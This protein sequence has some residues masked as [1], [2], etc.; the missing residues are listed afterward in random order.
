MLHFY[1][2]IICLLLFIKS[3]WLYKKTPYFKSL[4][5]SWNQIGNIANTNRK[6]YSAKI[7]PIKYNFR[8]KVKSLVKTLLTKYK[9][10]NSFHSLHKLGLVGMVCGSEISWDHLSDV[11]PEIR[12]K[13]PVRSGRAVK[14]FREEIER[15]NYVNC[16]VRIPS[17]RIKRGPQKGTNDW[18]LR[19]GK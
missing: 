17:Q 6:F 15:V 13:S 11:W 14:E 3:P 7:F 10:S 2:S 12:K 18:Q 5:C 4:N 8:R 1:S 19:F 9:T 16:F